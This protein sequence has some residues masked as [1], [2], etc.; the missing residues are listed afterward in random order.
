[1]T[2]REV[3]IP[4]GSAKPLAPY[5]P[6][7]LVNGHLLFTSGQVGIDPEIGKLVEGG[8]A[9]QAE[10]VMKNIKVLL[11]AAGAGFDSVIK[12]TVFLTDMNDYGTV[13][14]IYGKYFTDEP[15]ARS[16]I[17]VVGLPIGALVEIEAIAIVKK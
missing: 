11:E 12:T 2:S 17:A 6:A 1:M 4:E 8:V 14:E 3:I 15:P 10:Q 16:A 7:I 13:N 5:S 9:A